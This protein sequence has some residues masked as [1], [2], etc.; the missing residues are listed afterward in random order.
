M[1]PTHQPIRLC[2][3]CRKRKFKT[4]LNRYTIEDGKLINDKHKSMQK[5]GIYICSSDCLEKYSKRKI[6]AKKKGKQQ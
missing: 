6:R 5:R 3:S 1:A 4:E 2:V